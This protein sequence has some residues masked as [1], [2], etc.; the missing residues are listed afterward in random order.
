MWAPATLLRARARARA[1]ARL[2][3]RLRLR[4]RGVLFIYLGDLALEGRDVEDM[5][6]ARVALARGQTA[7]QP[8]D[9]V[10]GDRRGM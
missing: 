5:A 9:L 8:A 7:T 4:L 6:K 1:R 3:L 10:R 2:R